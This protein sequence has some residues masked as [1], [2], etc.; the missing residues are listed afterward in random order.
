MKK[1]EHPQEITITD[2]TDL[3]ECS[4]R[5]KNKKIAMFYIKRKNVFQTMVKAYFG[6]DGGEFHSTSS[7]RGV[8]RINYDL[9]QETLHCMIAVQMRLLEYMQ[10]E[11]DYFK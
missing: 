9:T 5:Y 3:I 2:Y 1:S 8:H 4:C 6:K 10:N 7:N 11:T